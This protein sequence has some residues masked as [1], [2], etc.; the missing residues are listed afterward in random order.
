MQTASEQG[1]KVS[2][3]RRAPSNAPVFMMKGDLGIYAQDEKKIKN[4]NKGEW[5]GKEGLYDCLRT[6]KKM[7]EDQLQS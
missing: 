4:Q 3:S 5:R 7:S 2:G 1:S 6:K